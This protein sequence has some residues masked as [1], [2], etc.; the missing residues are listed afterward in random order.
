MANKYINIRTQ[1]LDLHNSKTI[2][3]GTGGL[4]LTGSEYFCICLQNKYICTCF[5]NKL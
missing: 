3:K 2:D 5:Q 1:N 4:C